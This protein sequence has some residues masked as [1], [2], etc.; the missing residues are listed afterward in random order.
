[1]R[2]SFLYRQNPETLYVKYNFYGK[3]RRSRQ[4]RPSSFRLAS[5]LEQHEAHGR[6][7]LRGTEHPGEIGEILSPIRNGQMLF[8]RIN[9]P[10]EG[11]GPRTTVTA[12]RTCH[13]A[14]TGLTQIRVRFTAKR[15]DIIGQEPVGFTAKRLQIVAQVCVEFCA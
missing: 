11:Q 3:F 14:V 8:H 6:S 13:E 10:A 1:M 9:R 12:C 7:V 15:L 4:R 2:L 5:A